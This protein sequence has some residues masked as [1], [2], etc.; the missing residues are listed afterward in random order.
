[1]SSAPHGHVQPE[2]VPQVPEYGT[3]LGSACLLFLQGQT[4]GPKTYV[5]NTGDVIYFIY[6]VVSLFRATSTAYGG[7][8]ARGLIGAIAAG[9]RHSHSNTGFEPHL[10][11]IPQLTAMP[12]P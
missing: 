1:M 5:M 11:P 10:Q 12:D 6:F 4:F 9:L 7:S 2:Q 8:Q 3:F